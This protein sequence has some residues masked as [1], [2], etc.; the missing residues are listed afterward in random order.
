MPL[1]FA[2]L[3]EEVRISGVHG[4]PAVKQHLNELG[5]NT[6]SVVTVIQKVESGVIV[7]VK[8]AR[9]ALDSAMASKIMV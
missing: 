5:F 3:G 4:S 8:E 6:G 7:K 9:V 2:D 1:L